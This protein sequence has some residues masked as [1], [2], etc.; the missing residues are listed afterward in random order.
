M[1]FS[2]KTSSEDFPNAEVPH[3]VQAPFYYTD[4]KYSRGQSVE[5][6]KNCDDTSFELFEKGEPTGKCCRCGEDFK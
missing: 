5:A 6:C 2:K 3:H 4:K 1:K